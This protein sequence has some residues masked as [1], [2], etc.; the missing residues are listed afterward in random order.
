MSLSKKVKLYSGDFKS[1]IGR[2]N[3]NI[4]GHYVGENWYPKKTDSIVN[5]E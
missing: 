3:K 2:L 5:R 4:Q 1:V